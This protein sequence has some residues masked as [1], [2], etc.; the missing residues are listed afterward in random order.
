M[1]GI[2]HI[3]SLVFIRFS[4]L[5]FEMKDIYI[6]F[7][8]KKPNLI[9]MLRNHLIISFLVLLFAVLNGQAQE[10]VSGKSSPTKHTLTPEY[11]RG[12]PPIL[13]A[14]LYF[15]DDNNNSILEATEKARLTITIRNEGK[16]KAQGL[17]V[18]ARD[19]NYD[20][21]LKIGSARTIPF[22]LPDQSIQ[23]VFPFE[24]GM[25][26]R[27]GEHKIEISV[28]E[29]FGYD[30]DQGYLY[31]NTIKFQA[32]ELAFSGLELVDI[33][34]GTAAIKEDRQL[35]A[36]ELVKVKII[37]QNVGQNVANNT[38]YLVRSRDE[39]IYVEDGE[40]TLGNIDIGEVKEFWVTISPNKRVTRATN[41]PLY[42]TLT[43][44][45]H[46][47]ELT[48]FMLPLKLD[49]QP[50]DPVVLRFHLSQNKIRI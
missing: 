22:L 19:L 43:N 33:G 7:V 40:G 4:L 3:E 29:H 38:R 45:V 47:G 10:I 13:Y 18:S 48:D 35:Q 44:Q 11:Q 1:F 32:P 42:L 26:L 37:V 34:P 23:V 15:E 46:R 24:A 50:A 36:G 30:M 28:N 6:I 25:D 49:Q 9:P 27:S 5:T 39:N 31:V 41:L 2:S 21:A 16:G 17:T 8:R 20:K 14:D 12:L